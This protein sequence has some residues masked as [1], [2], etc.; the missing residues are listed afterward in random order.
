MKKR[1]I[2]ATVLV[3]LVV[4]FVPMLL[5]HEPVLEQEIEQSNIPPLP[6]GGEFNSRIIPQR[7]E[8]PRITPRVAQPVGND[9][10][11]PAQGPAETRAS[12][13]P[14]PPTDVVA[15]REG[16]SA[17]V[18]QVGSFSQRENAQNLVERLRGKS[19]AVDM[20]QVS[21]KGKTLYRVMVG[22]EV[23]RAQAEAI[24]ARVNKEVESLKLVGTLRSYP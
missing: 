1:L 16:L 22:P 13:T 3:S 12:S 17:W 15:T 2:G 21:I 11:V 4:I 23:D 18:V 14:N 24:L 8:P 10:E 7:S 5:E 9:A 20:E 19:F 6:P